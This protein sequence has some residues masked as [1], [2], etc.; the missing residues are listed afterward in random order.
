[1]TPEQAKKLI[2]DEVDVTN[3][4]VTYAK[5]YFLKN[6]QT[7]T[8]QLIQ[9]LLVNVE[10]IKPQ[11]IVIHPSVNTE[12]QVSK[13]VKY[14]SW[15]LAA[16]EAV[17]GL[18][19][20]NLLIPAK[21]SHD[22]GEISI[23]WTTVVPGSGGT[24]SGWRF[25]QFGLPLPINV[26]QRPSGVSKVNQPISDP[27][28]YMK[29]LGVEGINDDIKASLIESVL[30][31]KNELYLGCLALLG[32]AAEGAWIELGISLS[33]A[34]PENSPINAIKLRDSM[35]DQ[36]KGIGKKI[37]EVL[38]AYENRNV[39]GDIYRASGY[40]PSDLK[41]CVIWGDAVR[42]SRNSIHYGAEPSMT[43]S[44]EKVS[45]LLIGAVPNLKVIYSIIGACNENK[46]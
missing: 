8:S 36:F 10:A 33:E 28:L 42:E 24:S 26:Y 37:A 44:Y 14:I 2:E 20:N 4:M 17:W 18:I 3:Q 19:S 39:F 41:S 29:E 23:D 32:R 15:R 35:E 21:H 1:M 11:T 38:K 46:A 7:S 5:S 22:E 40:K 31:F 9:S 45:A 13:A 6:H 43:N 30:C 27:D 12:E 25:N 16:R 34:I